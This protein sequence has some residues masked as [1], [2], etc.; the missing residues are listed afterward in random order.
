MTLTRRFRFSVFG[1]WCG[2][3]TPSAAPTTN[4]QKPTTDGGRVANV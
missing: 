3:V 1:F 4:N 2:T